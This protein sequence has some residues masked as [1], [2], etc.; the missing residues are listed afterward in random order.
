MINNII[1]LKVNNSIN[2]EVDRNNVIGVSPYELQEHFDD[3]FKFQKKY[4]KNQIINL[5]NIC[6][7]MFNLMF[8]GIDKKTKVMSF[9]LC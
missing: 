9:K 5:S 8:C 6:D 7:C 3:L 1:N 4:Y 2:V